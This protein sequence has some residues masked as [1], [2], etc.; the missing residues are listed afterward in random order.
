L[1]LAALALLLALSLAGCLWPALLVRTVA[2]SWRGQQLDLA[3]ALERWLAINILLL[4]AQALLAARLNAARRFHWAP[5]AAGLPAAAVVAVLATTRSWPLASRVLAIAVGLT[6]GSAL[7]TALMLAAVLRLP[8]A[9]PLPRDGPQPGGSSKPT[10][11]SVRS[12]GTL[13]AAMGVL[14][15]VPWGERV[16]ASA[17]GAGAVAALDYGQRLVLFLFGLSVAP[18]TAVVF[19]RLSELNASAAPARGPRQSMDA[20]LSSAFLLQLENGLRAVLVAVLPAA[21]G[22]AVFPSLIT[23]CVY[24]WGRFGAASLAA[25]APVV[26]ILG[27]GL[28]LDAAFYYLLFALYAR[29]RSGAKLPLALLLAAVNLPLAWLGG[30]AWGVAGIAGA[31]VASTLCALAWLAWR[32]PAYFPGLR[33]R[34]TLRAAA[35]AAALSLSAA[36]AARMLIPSPALA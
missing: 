31:H 17:L 19:T 3:L 18:F 10:P 20:D 12:L 35:A 16:V 26:G 21:A 32:C 24:G 8:P 33:W 28:G 9:R 30:H 34:R 22:L 7:G 5:L 29:Q 1:V 13:V 11:A 15:L 4:G 27:A 36:L 2:P 25:T 6:A 23:R 14:N